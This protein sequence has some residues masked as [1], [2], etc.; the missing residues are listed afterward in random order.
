MM[1][2]MIIIILKDISEFFWEGLFCSF[3]VPGVILTLFLPY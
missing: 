3:K 1:M 2:M